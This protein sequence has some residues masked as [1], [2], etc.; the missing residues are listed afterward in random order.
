MD[1]ETNCYKV[2]MLFQRQG[3]KKVCGYALHIHT[4]S[5]LL[6]QKNYA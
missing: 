5:M 4:P 6:L 3:D 2:T 1:Y